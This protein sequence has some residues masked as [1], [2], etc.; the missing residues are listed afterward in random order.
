MCVRVWGLGGRE[1]RA[2]EGGREIKEGEGFVSYFCF[3][4]AVAPELAAEGRGGG[5]RERRRRIS[6]EGRQSSVAAAAAAAEG[7][8]DGQTDRRIELP[9]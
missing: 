9:S 4:G 6:M 2:S 5:A 7:G 3:D 8:M 1:R